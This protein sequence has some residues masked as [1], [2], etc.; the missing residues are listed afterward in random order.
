MLRSARSSRLPRAMAV[1]SRRW[2]SIDV[3]ANSP[4]RYTSNAWSIASAPS[5]G[6]GR[7]WAFLIELMA[8]PARKRTLAAMPRRSASARLRMMFP[9]SSP[10]ARAIIV[11]RM[12]GKSRREN[13]LRRDPFVA[14]RANERRA[15]PHR[16]GLA[17]VDAVEPGQQVD[18]F[19][20]DAA[21]G[22]HADARVV[23]VNGRRMGQMLRRLA[24]HA[25][26]AAAKG[27]A[28]H[29]AGRPRF[30]HGLE[31]LRHFVRRA[32]DVRGED[33]PL[34]AAAAPSPA[35]SPPPPRGRDRERAN[36][37]SSDTGPRPP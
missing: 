35:R 22:L 18:H 5:F 37:P 8:E 21:A 34:A 1:N 10:P 12:P 13:L 24:D 2:L 11:G 23:A 31:R 17:D 14:V 33:Q 36:S 28:E 20:E 16:G 3:S 26:G 7:P 4:E 6:S 25:D 27:L 15:G 9:W 29:H 32:G 19:A 30:D